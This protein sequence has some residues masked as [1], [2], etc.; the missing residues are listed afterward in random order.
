MT[1]VPEFHS[2][3]PKSD[4]APSVYHDQSACLVGK[5]VKPEHP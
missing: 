5:S 1:R 2:I 3:F 4:G